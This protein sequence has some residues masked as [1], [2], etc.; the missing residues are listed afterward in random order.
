MR[1]TSSVALCLLAAVSNAIPTPQE[2]PSSA[3]LPTEA[4]SDETQA[5]D[6]LAQLAE[7]AAQSTNETLSQNEKRGGC[8]L[9]NLSVR[10]EW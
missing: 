2:D 9:W 1:L 7:F 5:Q 6:Q 8:S 10:R 4:S 3:S